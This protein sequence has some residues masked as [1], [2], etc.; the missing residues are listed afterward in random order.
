[1]KVV[2]INC[3]ASGSTGNIAKAIHR[4]LLSQGDES[5]IFYSYGFGTATEQN[6]YPIGNYVSLHS[7]AVLSRYLG[8]QGY[9]SYFAT[10]KLI[11]QIARLKPD[12]IHLHNLHG[13]YLHLPSLFKFL[14]KSESNV[15]ITLHD[16]WLFTGKCPHFTV[17]GCHKWKE[18]CGSCPQLSI[19]PRSKVDTTQKSLQDKKKW[20]SGFGDRLRIV[21]VS[22]WL[23]DTA[24]QSYLSQYSI[25]T[26]YNGIN[27]DMFFPR[28]T[29]N[30][31]NKYN[32]NGKFV[33]LG[34]SSQWNEQKGLGEFLQL[35]QQLS[36]E[37]IIVLVGLTR[38]QIQS[39]PHNIIGIQRTENQEELAELYS[40]ADVFVNPSK[41]ET[42][43]LVTAEAMACGTPA[44]VYDSTACAEIVDEECGVILQPD[45]E[46]SLIDI[47]RNTQG[48]QVSRPFCFT[49]DRMVENY[50]KIYGEMKHNVG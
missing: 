16:C 12:V 39:L 28:E 23:R 46:Y 18:T 49:N 7:H 14:K 33:I 6:M 8:K 36:E 1:M 17:I 26:I 50:K 40:A 25:E 42:F 43:G 30:V 10:R 5:Y 32:L 48:K 44:I 11:R 27:V 20:L 22:N 3:S 37:E 19:Y 4:E 9:F 41:E 47:I 29:K 24:K 21:A 13:S 38:E 45:K 34:V 15:L 31:K 35:S 2:Q